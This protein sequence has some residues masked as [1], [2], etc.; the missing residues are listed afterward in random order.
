MSTLAPDTLALLKRLGKAFNAGDA[1]AILAC[2]TDD[3]EWIMA[4]GPDAPDGRVVRGREAVREAL[5]ARDREL[6]NIRF[7]EAEVFPAGDRVVGTY[8]MTATQ[9]DGTPVDI[10]GCDLYVIRD[11]LISRKDTYW[12][13]VA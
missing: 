4:R 8:R 6:R 11:G 5:A 13:Q 7:S 3:F 9:P 12:K 10:R 2:V 1:D